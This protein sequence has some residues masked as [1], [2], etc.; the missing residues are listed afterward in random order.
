MINNNKNSNDAIIRK[1]NWVAQWDWGHNIGKQANET[2]KTAFS[3]QKIKQKQIATYIFISQ[4]RVV[5]AYTECA[6][7]DCLQR[8]FEI[9]HSQSPSANNAEQKETV[10]NKLRRKKSAVSVTLE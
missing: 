3:K 1:K 7:T 10:W 8:R 5:G 2:E 9:Y 4:L 6:H